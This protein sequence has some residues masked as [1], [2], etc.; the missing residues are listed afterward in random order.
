MQVL[1]DSCDYLVVG[2]GSISQR[3]ISNLRAIYPKSKIGN[4]STSGKPLKHENNKVDFNFKSIE[5]AASKTKMFAIIASPASIHLENAEYFL[6][7]NIPVLIE[8]PITNDSK[9]LKKF[10][11]KFK[12][13]KNLIDVGYNY[14]FSSTLNTFKKF[15]SN[16]K[17]IGK[18]LSINVNV[19]Q[20]L[21]LWRKGKDYLET[22]SAK[23]SLGGGVLRELSHELD[24]ITWIFGKFDAVFCKSF[25]LNVLRIDVEESIDAIFFNKSGLSLNLH[26]DFLNSK[27]TRYCR[28][29]GEKGTL[30][31]DLINNSIFFSRLGDQTIEICEERNENR[32]DMYI[33]LLKNFKKV[34]LKKQKP[35]IS[36]EDSIY[37]TSLIEIM[38]T[39]S[40]KNS[41]CKIK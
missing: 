10:Y 34:S 20:H 23:E 11:E 37:L 41:L 9:K 36:P 39:S 2:T 32:N 33:K 16:K 13:K 1:S 35:N 15:L 21:S 17:K 24:Y 3:H 7:R 29:I 18:I 26:M 31:M 30:E 6:N 14:R 5:E 22:V 4:L 25:N 12:S 40:K 8:K 28:V 19:G 38:K 27:L